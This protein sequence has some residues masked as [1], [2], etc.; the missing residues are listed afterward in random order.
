[1]DHII[2]QSAVKINQL[3]LLFA[4]ITFKSAEQWE[5]LSELLY[6]KGE[7]HWTRC[8]SVRVDYC[9]TVGEKKHSSVSKHR[10]F[11]EA[12]R[13]ALVHDGGGSRIWKV[14]QSVSLLSPISI[15][16]RPA[17]VEKTGRGVAMQYITVFKYMICILSV[18]ALAPFVFGVNVLFYAAVEETERSDRMTEFSRIENVAKTKENLV[19]NFLG[20]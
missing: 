9:I 19:V 6:G 14:T 3:G 4:V 17:W 2:T 10:P 13:S 8:H 16:T 12:K 18:R 20:V 11:Q 15:C 1:M 5:E 7:R